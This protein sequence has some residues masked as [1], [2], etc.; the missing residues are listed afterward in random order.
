[1]VHITSDGLWK[2]ANV[3]LLNVL[4][5]GTPG[6]GCSALFGWIKQSLKVIKSGNYS[7]N[8]K[9]K[10]IKILVFNI[11]IKKMRM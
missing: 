5:S 10:K 11:Y 1:M 4:A 6:K 2:K 3:V 7:I 9:L 8:R